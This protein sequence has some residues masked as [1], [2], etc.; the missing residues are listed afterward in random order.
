MEKRKI[1]ILGLGYVGLTMAACLVT[2]GFKTIGVDM[3]SEKVAALSAK[4]CPIQEP[5]LKEL[6]AEG[7]A[8]GALE[9]TQDLGEAAEGSQITFVSVGTPSEPS[10]SINLEQI[11]SA[12][13][14]VGAALKKIDGYHLLVVRSTVTPGTTGQMVRRIIERR[15]GRSCGE[16]FGLC[17]NPEFM[18]EGAAVQDMLKPD[19]IVIGEY[20]AKSGNTLEGFYRE[21]YS[22]SMP[23]LIRTSLANAELIKYSN[24]AFLATKISFMNSIAN[25]CER[26]PE[27]DVDVVA[28]GIGL[29]PRIGPLFLRAGLGWGG[30]CLPK[31]SKA[32]LAFGRSLGVDLPIVHAALEINEIQPLSALDKARKAL[33]GLRGKRIAVLGLSFKP[34]TDDVREAISIRIIDELLR[35]ASEISVYDPAVTETTRR[36]LSGRVDFAASAEECIDGAD[37]CIIATEWDEFK[38]LR[39]EDFKRRMRRPVIIDGRRI[40]NPRE[41]EANT[42][43]YGVGLGRTDGG[44]LGA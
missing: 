19:R 35:E 30:S 37:C 22:D 18:K 34:E 42:E 11:R 16:D 2:R 6:I 36:N 7:L 40:Y 31:D 27:S 25:L 4:N 26:I 44:D 20:D 17:A 24:N 33:G 32:F 41:F 13:E 9:L 39:A 21:M 28:K 8:T 29:D 14:S 3:D 12:S 10:G 43:Y 15:S 5:G 23:A 38:R 1:I